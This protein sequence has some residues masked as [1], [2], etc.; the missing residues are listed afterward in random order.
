MAYGLAQGKHNINPAGIGKRSG[1]QV[2][3]DFSMKTIKYTGTIKIK[4]EG[5]YRE[6]NGQIILGKSHSIYIH[7]LRYFL[8]ELKIYADGMIDCWETATFEEFK[9]KVR[10]GWIAT[11]LPNTAEV[12]VSPGFGDFTATNIANVVKPE[13]LI[14]EVAD[15]IDELNDRPTTSDVCQ[16]AFEEYQKEPNKANTQKLKKAYEAIP[17]HN[18]IYVLGDMNQKDSPIRSVIYGE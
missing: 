13:E 9:N 10:S 15:I 2:E 4:S 1:T 17:E 18:R 6:E 3:S 16:K 5:I 11:E 7:N 8:T 14:K 12:S